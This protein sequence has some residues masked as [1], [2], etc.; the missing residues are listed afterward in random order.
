MC[1]VM[2]WLRPLVAQTI[3]GIVTYLGRFALLS[4]PSTAGR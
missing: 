4:L 1:N 3:Q 2:T